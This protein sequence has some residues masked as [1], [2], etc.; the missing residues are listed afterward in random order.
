MVEATLGTLGYPSHIL[1]K[2]TFPLTSYL[3]IRNNT[4]GDFAK[5]KATLTSTH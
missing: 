2:N 5:M 3:K 1:P 4:V